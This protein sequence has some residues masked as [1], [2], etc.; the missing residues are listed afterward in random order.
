MEYY[1]Q[2]NNLRDIEN[3]LPPDRDSFLATGSFGDYFLMFAL[4]VIRS[5]K[6]PTNIL[7]P[8]WVL[9]IIEIFEYD[10]ENL[11]VQTYNSAIQGHLHQMIMR[12][13]HYMANPKTLIPLLSTI[14]PLVPRLIYNGRLNYI[15][16][17][18]EIYE[19]E[20][21][22]KLPDVKFTELHE[23]EIVAI[24]NKSN[25][26][27][28]ITAIISID[29][30]TNPEFSVIFWTNIVKK[31]QKLGLRCIL[32]I[33]QERPEQKFISNLCDGTVKMPPHLVTGIIDYAKYSIGGMN[34]LMT[35]S[36]LF[37]K[38]AHIRGLIH[39]SS[40]NE[41]F[42]LDKFGSLQHLDKY[43]SNAAAYSKLINTDYIEYKIPL[44]SDDYIY[45]IFKK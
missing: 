34:G 19:M 43:V 37:C 21:V 30:N 12:R 2:L 25:I 15:N 28:N 16:L 29:N 35:I 38:Q 45:D 4:A 39:T 6:K 40:N 13:P 33:S 8:E 9:R 42:T 32:N 14:Y 18:C 27:P 5:R 23:Q 26:K 22:D 10:K 20:D 36:S 31:L 1:S 44:E 41:H 3:L 11:S 17:L 24:C 7:L